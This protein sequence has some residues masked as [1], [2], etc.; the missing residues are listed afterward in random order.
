MAIEG[1]GEV[2]RGEACANLGGVVKW[3]FMG[4]ECI[5]SGGQ[6]GADR[7]ALDWAMARGMR[8]GGWCPRGRAAEDGRIGA[9]YQLWETPVVE[10]AQRTEWNV[11]DA[12]ATVIFSFGV[13]LSGGSQYTAW[14]AR[15]LGRPVL[16]LA[17]GDVEVAAHRLR[18][19]LREHAVRILNVAGPRESHEPGIGDHVYAVLEAAAG[20]GGL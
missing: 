15:N 17:G 2:L 18:E 13:Q 14:L 4:L 20:M 3:G 8:H 7:A 9:K 16:H 1:R 11:R 6:T 10:Y 12:D 5:I 19:F